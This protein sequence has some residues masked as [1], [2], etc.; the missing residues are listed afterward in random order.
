M[1]FLH[2]AILWGLLALIIPILI[3]LFYFR[4]FKKVYFSNVKFLNEIKQETSSRNKIKNFLILLSR[5]LAL[6]ALILAFAQPFLPQGK[7]VKQGTR[8]VS[9]F[10]DN[11]FSMKA[12]SSDIPLF[13]KAKQK[14]KEIIQAYSNEDQFQ[15][16]SHDFK[17]K[18]Q[19]L[20]TKEDALSAIDQIEISPAVKNLD[21]IYNRQI[22]ALENAADLNSLYILSDFQQSICEFKS[23]MDTLYEV[24]FVP[25]QSVQ[26]SNVSIDSVWLA[27]PVLIPNQNNKL[28]IRT[29]NHSDRP[30]ENIRLT[31][32]QNGKTK[33]LGQINIPARS[34]HIDT[35]NVNILK[36]G[37]QDFSIKISDYPIQ[38][39]DEYLFSL[40]V[41][42]EI[43]VLSLNQGSNNKYLKSVFGGISYFDLK[44]ESVNK[45]QYADLKNYNLVILNELTSISSGLSNELSSY[46]VNGGNLLLF[47]SKSGSKDSYNGLLNAL[48]ADNI[49]SLITSKKE[50]SKIN[51][52]DFIF[53]EVYLR[54]NKNLK[55]PVTQSN[56]SFSK[57]SNRGRSD[58]LNYRDGS[59]Y[60][61]KYKKDQGYFYVCAAPLDVKENDL[62]LNAEVFVPMLFKMAL[63][64][65]T[66]STGSYTIGKNRLIE[67]DKSLKTGETTFNISG[68]KEFIPKQT[69]LADRVIIDVDDQVEEKG[70]YTLSLK[71]EDLQHLAFNYDRIES[72]LKYYGVTELESKYGSLGID[73]ISNAQNASFTELIGDKEKG[74]VL[75]KWFVILALIFLAIETL[76][77][78]F[79]K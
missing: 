70:T 72:D 43:K 44:N 6:G 56:Y 18:E 4:R 10:I 48:A 36:S 8:A 25:F 39:D 12:L 24:S 79:W 3:H 57:H 9:V 50:V 27:G 41:P 67:A 16:L 58:L 65:G 11:S 14:A 30:A 49:K 54:K 40:E 73:I 52:D 55:L 53:S 76:L 59:M 31:I 51:T 32:D 37:W 38:F 34:S 22:Q 17:V 64:K 66:A 63:N 75:W 29:V 1:E 47:P 46:V 2:P 33:P 77:I 19:R 62:S 78:R 35:A 71:D 60:L 74:V 23:T 45:F 13:D 28:I 61:G 42:Q 26:E 20:L 21:R 7:D 15:I 68:P 5:L 69:V